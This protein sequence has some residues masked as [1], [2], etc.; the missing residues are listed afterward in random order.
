MK[1][2]GRTFLGSAL[3]VFLF[4]ALCASACWLLTARW[5]ASPPD[6]EAIP[7]PGSAPGWN[8]TAPQ[9]Q[10]DAPAD[11]KHLQKEQQDALHRT[12]WTD[13]SHRHARIPIE[14]A[15][16]LVSEGRTP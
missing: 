4:L 8:K 6:L 13:A 7:A 16:R 12:E 1:M 11:W 15:M 10:I 14:E 5:A 2:K 9:L 3:G